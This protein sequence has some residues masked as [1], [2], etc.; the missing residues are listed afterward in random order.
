MVGELLTMQIAERAPVATKG[1]APFR[2]LVVDDSSSYR[3]LLSSALK[4]RGYDVCEAAD[5]TEALAALAEDTSV[6]MVVSDWEMPRTDGPELCRAVRAHDFGRYIYFILVTARDTSEDLV[7]GMEAGADDFLTKP[8]DQTELVVRMRAGERVIRL[9]QSLEERNRRLNAAYDLIKEDL[10]AAAKMQRTLLPGSESLS[11]GGMHGQ[12]MFLPSAF[13][14][15]DTLNFFSLNARTIGFYNIDV[16]GHG[17][18]AAMLSVT[19]S[20]LLA[21]ERGGGGLLMR[22]PNPDGGFLPS[23]P[24]TVVAGLNE[25]FQMT[26][27]DTTYF[28]LVYGTV[29]TVTGEG[30]L[31]QAGHTNP[32]LVSAGGRERIVGEGGF[33]VGMMPDAQFASIPFSLAAGDRLY[34]YSDGITECSCPSGA[35]YGEDRLFAFFRAADAVPL[36]EVTA[37]LERSLRDWRGADIENFEDDVS[38]LVIERERKAN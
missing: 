35:M 13:V 31:T 24:H 30:L 14:S 8:V 22:E 34:L 3:R 2:I 19:L 29:D 23:K 25:L 38:L 10:R 11:A 7:I 6:R 20:R 33:P 17:V 5:G 36:D 4:R 16:S 18:P 37:E 15:G 9:E 32:V 28:T 1:S 12:W 27:E 26:A 21:Q